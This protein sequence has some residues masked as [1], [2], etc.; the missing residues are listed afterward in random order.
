[1]KQKM[2]ILWGVCC[3]ACTSVW[4]I[5]EAYATE[6]STEPMGRAAKVMLTMDVLQKIC[7]WIVIG[8]AAIVLAFYVLKLILKK[9]HVPPQENGEETNDEQ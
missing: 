4:G 9:I 7:L 6:A 8:V 1:M 5:L 2:L 3:S